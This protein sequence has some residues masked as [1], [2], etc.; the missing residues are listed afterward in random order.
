MLF[1]I[2]GINWVTAMCPKEGISSG[3]T[4][5]WAVLAVII[6]M[7]FIFHAKL[8]EVSTFYGLKQ[9]QYKHNRKF[10]G[11]PNDIES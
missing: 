3:K 4:C 11:I 10:I 2:L 7:T 5:L 8:T 1:E 9:N 6:R